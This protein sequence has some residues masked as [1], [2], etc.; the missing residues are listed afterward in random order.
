MFLNWTFWVSFVHVVLQSCAYLLKLS[1]V[2]AYVYSRVCHIYT[3]SSKSDG[4]HFLHLTS[5]YTMPVSSWLHEWNSFV[6]PN[7]INFLLTSFRMKSFVRETHW[8]VLSRSMAIANRYETKLLSKHR[9]VCTFSVVSGAIAPGYR[10]ARCNI[11]WI[12]RQYYFPNQNTQRKWR[13]GGL[14]NILLH[15]W[16]W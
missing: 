1:E 8:G 5:Q 10:I 13:N 15:I 11:C 6:F 14:H 12:Y 4:Y 9:Y 16:E 2:V 7:V 3:N